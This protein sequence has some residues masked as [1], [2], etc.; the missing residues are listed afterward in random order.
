MVMPQE[1][2]EASQHLRK[3]DFKARTEEAIDPRAY[4]QGYEEGK[5]FDPA[6]RLGEKKEEM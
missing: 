4:V 5:E 3:G 1:V 6:H 2:V